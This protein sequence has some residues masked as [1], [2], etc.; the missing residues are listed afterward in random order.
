MVKLWVYTAIYG[1]ITAI[2]L[3]RYCNILLGNVFD[4]LVLQGRNV[5]QLVT[6]WFTERYD[7]L[8][9]EVPTIVR[10]TSGRA[11]RPCCAHLAFQILKLFGR[12][13][14]NGENNL[15]D[16]CYFLRHFCGKYV[17]N[18]FKS[19]GELF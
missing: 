17:Y 6:I 3:Q 15:G 10:V 4:G 14:F 19:F 5:G 18:R 12:A 9:Q 7:E 1:E 8:L 16:A 11:E 13:I 2:I